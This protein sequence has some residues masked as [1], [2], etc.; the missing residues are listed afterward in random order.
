[1]S[2]CCMEY[3]EKCFEETP[4]LVPLAIMMP[5]ALISGAIARGIII[6]VI[7]GRENPR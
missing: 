7:L 5:E 1:M 2:S 4:E 6:G 3:S